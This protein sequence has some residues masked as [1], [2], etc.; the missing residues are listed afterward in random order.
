MELGITKVGGRK[1]VIQYQHTSE[2]E[3]VQN[4][5]IINTKIHICL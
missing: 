2:A 4:H 5:I 3:I 1:K